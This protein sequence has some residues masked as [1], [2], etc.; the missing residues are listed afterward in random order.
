[1][2]DKHEELKDVGSGP[3]TARPKSV[4]QH[5]PLE[6]Q[7]DPNDPGIDPAEYNLRPG[8]NNNRTK[9]SPGPGG[10]VNIPVKGK[11]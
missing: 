5:D 3:P 10:P 8:D 9:D 2:A 7:I 6:G 4:G 11:E 1:M